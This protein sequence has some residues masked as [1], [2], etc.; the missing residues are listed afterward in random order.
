MDNVIDLKICEYDLVGEIIGKSFADDAVNLWVFRSTV[1]MPI[2]YSLCARKLYLDKGFGHK[3]TNNEAG[4]LWLPPCIDKE[5]P[6]WN[7]FDIAWYMIRYGGFRSIIN[8]MRLDACLAKKK[9]T[10]PHYYLYTIGVLPGRQ[11]QGLGSRLMKRGL[12]IVDS[13]AMPAYLESSKESNVPFYEN[14][15][16]KVIEK[17]QLA[18]SSLPMWLMWRE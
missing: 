4:T 9:P 5:I 3:T 11:G 7:S 13:A 6:F 10:T 15:G 12:S 16:F 14:F 2:F 17:I 8:G 18:D 1:V